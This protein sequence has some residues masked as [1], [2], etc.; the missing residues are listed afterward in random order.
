MASIILVVIFVIFAILLSALTVYSVVT[1]SATDPDSGAIPATIIIFFIAVLAGILM[2]EY[3]SNARE[4]D[5]QINCPEFEQITE[6]IYR[7]V[8]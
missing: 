2:L 4:L 7:K 3:R 5:E 1:I 8:K 6:P